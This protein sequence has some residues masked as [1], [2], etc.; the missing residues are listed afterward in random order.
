M[1]HTTPHR[2]GT[3]TAPTLF[4][5]LAALALSA[6]A[7]VRPGR[8]SRRVPGSHGH[9]RAEARGKGGVERG[10]AGVRAHGRRRE[11][12]GQARRVPLRLAPADGRFHPAGARRARRAGRR[13]APQGRPSSEG[14]ARRG[15]AVRRRG[16]P[17]RRPHVAAVPAREGRAHGA[18][19]VRDQGR[20]LPAARAPGQPL[21]D[22]GRPLR[23]A[24]QR[25]RPRGAAARRRGLRRPLPLLAQPRCRRAGDLPR[26]PHHPSRQG[27]LHS[28]PRL[29][30]QRAGD[31]GRG[32]GPAAGR[33]ALRGALRGPQLD[34]R[35]R[36]AHLQHQ[37]PRR[38]PRAGCTASI[39]RPAPPA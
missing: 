32:D 38:G 28:L 11:P 22:V 20:R 39:S 1:R 29:H 27:R 8:R 7:V 15:L 6:W 25:E 31:P 37:R 36:L 19:R 23:R 2:F 30:R 34:D 21:H 12:V 10:V 17:R 16:G 26:R 9:R 24:A 18:D 13:P 33:A 35:R 5:G 4:A 14:I 3:R